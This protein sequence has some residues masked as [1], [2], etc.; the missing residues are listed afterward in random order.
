MHLKHFLSTMLPG[1]NH[2]GGITVSQNGTS[3]APMLV[4]FSLTVLVQALIKA[5]FPGKQ[6]IHLI[7]R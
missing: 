6:K 7:K 3:A 4:L 1:Q 5:K 2:I